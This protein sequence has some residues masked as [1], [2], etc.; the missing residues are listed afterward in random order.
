MKQFMD[1]PREATIARRRWIYAAVATAAGLGGAGLAWWRFTAG[2]V[3]E[4]ALS[5]LWR[6]EFDTL[7]SA[8]L[9]MAGLRGRP[10]LINFW[11]T[12]CPPCIEELP[13]LDSFYRENQSNGWQV[14][15]LA[16]DKPDAV[17]DFLGRH[18]LG[19]P[20][21]IAGMDGIAL[22]KS[23]GNLSDGLPFTVVLRADGSV[24]NR[25]I[26]KVSAQDLALWRELK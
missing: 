19:F 22:S 26:G 1:E 14:I 24:Q 13:L 6:L 21:G 10:L 3:D 18:P 15:G 5:N 9:S 17:R 16:V 23:L 20:V 8:K 2:K 7:T 11:A 25:K 4:A 12:W